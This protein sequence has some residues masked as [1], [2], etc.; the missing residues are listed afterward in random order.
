[1]SCQLNVVYLLSQLTARGN[2][3]NV[4]QKLLRVAYE[5]ILDPEIAY[6]KLR[7]GNGSRH[8]SDTYQCPERVVRFA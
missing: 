3:A 4:R 1:M 7:A 5:G 8:E 2:A 6:S